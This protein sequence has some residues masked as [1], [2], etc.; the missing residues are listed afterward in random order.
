M[1]TL[2]SSNVWLRPMYVPGKDT[3]GPRDMGGVRRAANIRQLKRTLRDQIPHMFTPEVLQLLEPSAE[4]MICGFEDDDYEMGET[5]WNEWEIK[6]AVVQ[7]VGRALGKSHVGLDDVKAVLLRMDIIKKKGKKP[8]K[9][10]QMEKSETW[11]EKIER[12]KMEGAE[13]VWEEGLVDNIVNPGM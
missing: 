3:I 2:G 5:Y 13:C 8:G 4:P 1:G 9:T 7:M 6:K 12:V 11:A 10:R